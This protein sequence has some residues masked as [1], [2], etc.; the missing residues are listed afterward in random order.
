[1][2]RFTGKLARLEWWQLALCLLGV[3]LASALACWELISF[4]ARRQFFASFTGGFV[5]MAWVLLRTSR[6]RKTVE[7]DWVSS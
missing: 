4:V 7:E 2:A 5:A 6:R 3:G 1:M